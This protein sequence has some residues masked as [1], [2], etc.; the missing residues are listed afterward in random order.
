MGGLLFY[1]RECTGNILIYV[2][3]CSKEVFK[4]LSMKISSSVSCINPIHGDTGYKYIPSG[5]SQ[6]V[7]AC[8]KTH[9]SPLESKIVADSQ[10]Q[11]VSRDSKSA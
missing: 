4:I 10:I 6:S 11:A 7:T 8:L 3:F 5:T 1:Y 9:S 2:V